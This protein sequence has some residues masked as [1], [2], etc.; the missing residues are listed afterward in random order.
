MPVRLCVCVCFGGSHGAFAAVLPSD[1]R[2]AIF[3]Q[4]MSHFAIPHNIDVTLAYAVG[5]RCVLPSFDIFF[6]TLFCSTV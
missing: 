5:T 3:I 1:P 4:H 2:R 6:I